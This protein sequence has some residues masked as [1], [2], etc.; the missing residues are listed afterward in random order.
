M[1]TLL[2]AG[3]ITTTTY[4]KYLSQSKTQS[5]TQSNVYD[6]VFTVTDDPN[7]Y[8]SDSPRNEIAMVRNDLLVTPV[9]QYKVRK[10]ITTGTY[11]YKYDLPHGTWSPWVRA[12]TKIMDLITKKEEE[13]RKK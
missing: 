1:A 6:K 8:A 13:D 4:K 7:I 2:A 10:N 11:E 3:L 12:T 9:V 5:K